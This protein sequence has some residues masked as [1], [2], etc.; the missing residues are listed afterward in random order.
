MTSKS[1]LA[2]P[3]LEYFLKAAEA[4]SLTRAAESLGIRQ[5]SLTAAIQRLE[6]SLGTTLFVRG[7]RGVILTSTGRVL[8]EHASQALRTLRLAQEEIQ[9]LEEE[10]R[11]SF[12]IGVHES[13]AAYLLPG[14]MARF[15]EKHPKVD[16]RLWNGN[17][18]EVPAA[19]VER[20]IDLGIVVNPQAHPECVL[21]PLFSDRVHFMLSAALARKVR[22]SLAR[23]IGELP[24]IYVP[25]LRQ[26]QFLIGALSKKGLQ[27]RRELPC[28]SLELVKSLVLDGVGLGILPWR[29]A[30]HG[31][32]R[33][34]IVVAAPD[35][36]HYDDAIALVR[37]YDMHIT[38]TG[39]ILLDALEEHGKAMPSLSPA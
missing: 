23:W 9:G 27:A 28:S 29:V 19:V 12:T 17:S 34:R 14:F 5:P 8:R 30:T 24:L 38:K 37:R 39:R 10:P 2:G 18:R 4:G 16:L 25:A 15:I 7:R 21:R 22:R 26:T 6:K 1:P 36:P 13:L 3:E 20:R 31:V 33:G 11:G 32:A 35:L